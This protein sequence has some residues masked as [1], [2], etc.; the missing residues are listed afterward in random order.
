MKFTL[1]TVLLASFLAVD[2][3][4]RPIPNR[5]INFSAHLRAAKETE[6]LRKARRL[7]EEEFLT[8][9]TD[10]NT[11]VLDARSESKF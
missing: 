8:H 2:A 3:A 10:P 5:K 6:V 4:E 9:A 11:V 7:T 1:I